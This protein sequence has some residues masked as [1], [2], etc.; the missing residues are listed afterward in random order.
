MR[1]DTE[2]LISALIASHPSLKLDYNAIA[3]MY[4]E[5]ANYNTM[6]HRFRRYRK[7]AETLR[8]QHQAGVNAPAA[9]TPQPRTSNPRRA[10][11]VK[12]EPA[13]TPTARADRRKSTKAKEP[14]PIFLSDTEQ[15][16]SPIKPEIKCEND[17]TRALL[18]ITQIDLEN[19][20]NV[21]IKKR[22][23]ESTV[24]VQSRVPVSLE[25]IPEGPGTN[26][27]VER[28]LTSTGVPLDTQAQ[29]ND[30]DLDVANTV[31]AHD[32]YDEI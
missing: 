12:S 5:G 18:G 20:S 4:G 23:R 27:Q 7:E 22:K 26:S 6:E 3:D 14:S 9:F 17:A 24:S 2:K 31:P 15:E 28:T 13:I 1:V 25:D 8:A 10:R 32:G 30:G 29:G 21:P 19:E 16:A 11:Q